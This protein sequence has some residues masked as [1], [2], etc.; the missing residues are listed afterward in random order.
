MICLLVVVSA[1]RITGFNPCVGRLGVAIHC[2]PV[3][4][5]CEARLD[6]QKDFSFSCYRLAQGGLSAVARTR[7]DLAVLE[8][9]WICCWRT[10]NSRLESRPEFADSKILG[11]GATI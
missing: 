2:A 8:K 10:C 4:G 3:F 9:L 5:G 1:N 7:P 11:E 6:N